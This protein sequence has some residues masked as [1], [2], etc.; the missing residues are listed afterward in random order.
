MRHYCTYFDSNYLPMGL[1]LYSSLREHER[2]PFTLWTLCFDDLTYE[3]LSRLN[4]PGLRPIPQAVF[5]AGDDALVQTKTNRSRVEYFFT[6]TPS[7]PLYVFKQDPTVGCIT[8]LDADLFF[9]ASPDPIFEEL[10]A[11][12]ILIVEHRFP[13]ESNYHNINGIYNVGL[14][15]FRR[16]ENGWQ[17]LQWWRERNIEW[18][19]DRYEDGKYADQKYLD[20]W[21]TRFQGVVVLKNPTAG[22]APWNI[23]RQRVRRQAGQTFLNGAPLI[24]YHFHQFRLLSQTVFAHNLDHYAADV[25]AH[26]IP[27]EYLSDLYGPYAEAVSEAANRLEGIA[28]GIVLPIDSR[29]ARWRAVLHAS[30]MYVLAASLFER[31]VAK[32]SLR[33]VQGRC[34]ALHSF[35]L[36][37]QTQYKRALVTIL[38]AFVHN[39]LFILD[40]HFAAM[41]IQKLRKVRQG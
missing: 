7:L 3:A 11:G 38:S 35:R 15:S 20:D 14:L 34:L 22:V 39:P 27:L 24:F 6:C 32:V 26:F 37:Y 21:L 2:H 18:C 36:F 8:Y 4:L 28:P 5:E 31:Q 13:P 19:Y 17:A 10:K 40:R 41:L 33:L 1:A 23:T 12:S 30:K 25:P 9:F 16:D 29:G